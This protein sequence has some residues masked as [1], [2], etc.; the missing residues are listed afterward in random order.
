MFR[1]FDELVGR[2]DD[3]LEKLEEV[4]IYFPRKGAY[5]WNAVNDQ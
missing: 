1:N 4:R 2:V 3:A 5:N